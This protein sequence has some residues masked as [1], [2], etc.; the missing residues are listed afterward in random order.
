MYL[1]LWD[2]FCF[3]VKYWYYSDAADLQKFSSIKVLLLTDGHCDD[4]LQSKF[5]SLVSNSFDKLLTCMKFIPISKSKKS[6]YSAKTVDRVMYSSL[7]ID[8]VT[9]NKCLKFKNHKFYLIR[10][11]Q[12][13]VKKLNLGVTPTHWWKG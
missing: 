8:A 2:W 12:K 3:A 10:F 6:H 1:Y 13:L 11:C 4:K 7:Q 9:I 5:Q